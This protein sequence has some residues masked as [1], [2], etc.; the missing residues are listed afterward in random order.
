VN[1]PAEQPIRVIWNANAGKRALSINRLDGPA[2]LE[3]LREAGLD[4]ELCQMESPEDA[5]ARASEAVQ[6]GA[7]IVIAAGGD[8]TIGS[9]AEALLDT[10][11]ALC[12]I[13][14]GSVMNI[15]RMLDIPR[16]ADAAAAIIARGATRVIDVGMANGKLF[17]EMA[18]VGISATIFREV[19]RFENGDYG[20]PLRALRNAFRYRPARMTIELEGRTLRSRALMVAVGN[21]PYMGLGM[22]VAPGASLDDGQ[23]DVRVFRHFSKFELFRHMLSIA[24]GRRRY[25]PHVQTERSNYVRIEAARPLPARADATWLG[26]T[27]L[28]CRVRPA[29]LRVVVPHEE[30]TEG[31]SAAVD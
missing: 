18:S 12:I 14:M 17:Y 7:K 10:Q 30:G 16:D 4:V 27:P 28:E 26:Y 19:E 23:F 9:V 21:G 29:A 2:L 20:S 11:T 8:G 31:S 25:S 3:L 15:P 24:F 22:T 1:K 13:P 5:K 6:A